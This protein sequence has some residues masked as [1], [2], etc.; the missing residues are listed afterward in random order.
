M[1]GPSHPAKDSSKPAGNRS[2]SKV[3]NTDSPFA[4]SSSMAAVKHCS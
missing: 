1:L 3:E 2:S 4:Q